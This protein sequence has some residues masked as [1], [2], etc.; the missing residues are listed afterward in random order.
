MPGQALGG[1]RYLY[2]RC[3]RA[4]SGEFERD[5]CKSRYIRC[6]VLEPAVRRAVASVIADPERIAREIRR[7][8]CEAAAGSETTRLEKELEQVRARQRRLVDALADGNL[9]ADLVQQRAGQLAREAGRVEAALARVRYDD[10][11]EARLEA[12][13]NRLPEIARTL[14]RWVASVEGDEHN[15]LME[16]LDIRVHASTEK[17][18]IRGTIP[19]IETDQVDEL[20][21][22]IARTSETALVGAQPGSSVGSE[23]SITAPRLSA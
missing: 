15:L 7:L 17:L 12:M 13:L 16:A 19:D 6:D 5:V 3:R 11:A 20:L 9:P 10:V 14:G 18:E 23:P 22:T 2:Y 4:F 8:R 21:V 1:G